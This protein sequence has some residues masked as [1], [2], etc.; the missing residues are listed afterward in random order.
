MDFQKERNLIEQVQAG[1]MGAFEQLYENYKDPAF[2]T[3]ALMTGNPVDAQDVVQDT[4]VTVFK[5]IKQLKDPA[6]F[7]SWFYRILTRNSIHLVQSRKTEIP[8]DKIPE[9]YLW[10]TEEVDLSDMLTKQETNQKLRRLI[11]GMDEKHRTVLVLYYYNEFSVGQIAQITG[12]L[13]GTVKSRLYH[14][15]KLLEQRLSEIER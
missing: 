13:T 8:Q 5:K 12:C 10:E 2:R 1:Q 11:D 3:A 7:R 9:M 4:F 6:A 15:R 14:A